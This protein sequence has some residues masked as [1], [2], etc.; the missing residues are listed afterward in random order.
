[1]PPSVQSS[2]PPPRAL[3]TE[4]A[5]R[6]LWDGEEA[7]RPCTPRAL[8]AAIERL[9][10]PLAL[11]E[12]PHAEPALRHV[13]AHVPPLPPEA[14]GDASFRADHGVAYAYA[15]G[16]MANGIAS[17]ELVAAMARAG[18]LSFFGTAG[19][20][21]DD[22][23]LAAARLSTELDDEPYGFN[24]IHSPNEPRLESQLVDLY[25]ARG[26]RL[27]E[28]S[29]F[30][31]LTLPLV[32][33]RTHGIHRGPDGR[34]VTPNRVVAK[35]SRAEV[36]ARF[37]SPPPAAL[38]EQLVERG[39]LTREQASL[40]ATVPVAAD[41]TAEADSGGHTD[42]RSA[43]TL[44]PAMIDLARRHAARYPT[45]TRLRVG[46]AGGLSTP[47]SV[48]GAFA[49]GAAWVLTGTINQ[50]C[51]EA[52]TS[53][54]VRA[55]LAEAGP[56]DVAMAPA[57]DMF[58]MGVRVQVLKRGTLFAMRAARLYELYRAHASL[59][60]IPPDERERLER[61]ILGAPVQTVWERTR[62]FFSERDP[63]Q[64][65][66]AARDPRHR[67]AL[68]FRWYLGMSS[69]WANHGDSRRRADYQVW[70]GPAMGAFNAWTEGSFLAEPAARSAPVVARALLVGAAIHERARRLEQQGV[71][72]A[73][74]RPSARPRTETE[75]EEILA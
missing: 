18:M 40:A 62:A 33:Y 34:A 14:L 19:L 49:L 5:A 56:A 68:V 54:D 63:E 72:L 22:V 71:D 61:T 38:L 36:A 46:A 21:I 9:R 41:L 10:R 23:A 32:R 28:A 17:V 30:L 67:M 42:N 26:V 12:T 11:L 39:D 69:H 4:A 8:R 58:E 15:A 59:E 53:D 66:R 27:V 50:A 7:A 64:L 43:L 48:A 35:A 47:E 24:F 44:L 45:P 60:E 57:A 55:M 75:I 2:T 31:D 3:A 70:C 25:L 20:T 13:V 29:A 74:A 37:F 65:E 52:G 6:G 73:D 1:V 16:A 51:V